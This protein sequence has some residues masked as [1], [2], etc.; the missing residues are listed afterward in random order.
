MRIGINTGEIV[1][2][3]M[4]STMRMN[5][6]MMGDAVNLAARLEAAAKQYG[7]YTLVS[8]YTLDTPVPTETSPRPLRELVE[9]RL[10]DNITVVGRSEPVKVYELCALKGGLTPEE[11]QLFET[12]ETGLDHYL[13]MEWDQAI[14]LFRKARTIERFPENKVTPSDIYIQRCA[15]YKKAPPVKPGEDWDGVHRLTAK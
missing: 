11:A 5:Y 15:A 3:N 12:F 4:G 8:H 1:V 14:E 10:I 9:T 2:G 6:T 13:R 7:L